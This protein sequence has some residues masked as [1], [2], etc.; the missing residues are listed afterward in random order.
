VFEHKTYLAVIAREIFMTSTRL[1][2]VILNSGHFMVE[3]SA[4]VDA[5]YVF[6]V[7]KNCNCGTVME[8]RRNARL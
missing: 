7:V 5:H 1:V 8:Q 6:Q 4:V 3:I 2:A